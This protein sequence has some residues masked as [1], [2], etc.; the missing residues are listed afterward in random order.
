MSRF[1]NARRLALGLVTLVAACGA[2]PGPTS[3]ASGGSGGATGG[4][5]SPPPAGQGGALA[6]GGGTP[7]GGTA[8][9]AGSGGRSAGT[10]ASLPSADAPTSDAP[11][12]P[13]TGA[14]ALP[15]V[16]TDHFG[17]RGWFGDGSIAPYFKTGSMLIEEVSSTTGPCAARPSGARGTCLRITYTPPAGLPAAPGA[18][19]LGSYM[20]T[21]IAQAHPTASP[22]A[23]P[24]D[25]NWGVEPGLAIMPGAR[26]V[27]FYA[28]APQPSTKI[29]FRAGTN[30]DGVLLPERTEILT[31][32]WTRYTMPLA[33]GQTGPNLLGGFA[34]TLKNTGRPATFYLD[35]IVWEAEGPVPPRAPAGQRDGVRQLTFINRC[36]EPIHVGAISQMAV[37][38]GG[39]FL[40]GAGQTHVT[41]V[42]G[43]AWSG[44]FWGRT[45]CQ[46]DGAGV[47]SCK[48][49]DCAG[50]LKCS[51][52]GK[53]PA[54]LAEI[55]FSAGPP[56][57]D[58]YDISL[59]D[60]YNLPMA[61]APLPG[62]HD[63]NPGAPYDCGTP[64]CVADL[65]PTC[66]AE[67]RVTNGG[68]TVGCL[69]ACEKLQSDQFCCRGAFGTPDT[70]PPFDDSRVFKAA[71]PTAY[72]YAYDDATS[73]F[74]CKG[75][76]YAIWFCPEA[77]QP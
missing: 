13:V 19:F 28:A 47:G 27:S 54:T 56:N 4:A 65:N 58:F 21:S 9:S 14:V 50:G 35:D 76:D 23:R 75:E 62:T 11:A 57:P 49:G 12:G 77:G 29:A 24:G 55:T 45:G 40:L 61:I 46:F 17:N 8:G 51:G 69:S 42:P 1:M 41:T 3:S 71:C 73:T 70:C 53:T 31:P 22:P 2:T 5:G 66:P 33:G 18:S 60:G 36:K 59:V 6:G 68:Q 48:T 32:Q 43:G 72:S 64:S 16:V 74:T 30:K 15:L 7:A 25:P 44:R 52:G 63:R 20:L 38:E 67:L 39:G 26:Q 34:W 37:P 10:D